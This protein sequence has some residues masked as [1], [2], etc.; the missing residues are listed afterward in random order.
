MAA[1][2]GLSKR[3]AVTPEASLRSSAWPTLTPGMSVRRFF[4]ARVPVRTSLAAEYSV[5]SHADVKQ[6]AGV[7]RLVPETA[8][9]TSARRRR[10]RS[11]ES[12]LEMEVSE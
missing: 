3:I 12:N 7:A 1:T 8:A 9:W 11:G 6:Q 10:I 4:K 5:T 2:A